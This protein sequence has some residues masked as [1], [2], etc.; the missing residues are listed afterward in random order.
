MTNVEAGLK[1]SPTI[2]MLVRSE[3]NKPAIT[4]AQ[5]PQKTNP[6]DCGRSHR[7]PQRSQYFNSMWIAS[8]PSSIEPPE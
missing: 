3:G 2:D 4:F 1:P 5:A 7:P 6:E 8:T